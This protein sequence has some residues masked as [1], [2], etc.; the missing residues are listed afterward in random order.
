MAFFFDSTLTLSPSLFNH[1]LAILFT[2]ELEA[3]KI[4]NGLLD[5]WRLSM[6]NVAGDVLAVFVTLVVVVRPLGSL[7]DN[8]ERPPF[9]A[10]DLGNL[11]KDGVGKSCLA[12]G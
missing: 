8:V 4:F 7:P 9:H 10:L 6:R 5:L 2:E 3:V 1:E 12:H 11:L